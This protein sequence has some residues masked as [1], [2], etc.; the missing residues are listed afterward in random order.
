MCSYTFPL[1]IYIN[2]PWLELSSK[3]PIRANGPENLL[4]P[5]WCDTRCWCK[6]RLRLHRLQ[7]QTLVFFS[8]FLPIFF[9]GQPEI[10]SLAIWRTASPV[11]N[12]VKSTNSRCPRGTEERPQHYAIHLYIFFFIRYWFSAANS[13]SLGGNNCRVKKGYNH[14][15]MFFFSLFWIERPRLKE[16]KNN[17]KDLLP[18]QDEEKILLWPGL[19]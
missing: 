4:Q 19:S 8:I 3:D 13:T 11:R 10:K 2:L 1:K 6:W 9:S 15:T 17:N 5:C 12:Y 18:K 16:S 7:Q 14:L